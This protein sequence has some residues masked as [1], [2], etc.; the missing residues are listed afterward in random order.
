VPD[1]PSSLDSLLLLYD[2][3]K[4]AETALF[5]AAYCAEQWQS[6]LVVIVPFGARRGR[7]SARDYLDEY[8][9][10]HEV[11]PVVLEFPALNAEVALRTA[12]EHDC[13]FIVWGEIA[14]KNCPPLLKGILS[15]WTRPVL[16][17]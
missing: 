13:Q 4:K 7:H 17:C 2:G 12:V 10:I 16:I 11:T 6:R 5:I 1:Q 15:H 14:R 9:E 8:L 3:S